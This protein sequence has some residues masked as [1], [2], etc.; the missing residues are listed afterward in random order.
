MLVIRTWPYHVLGCHTS[1][2]TWSHATRVPSCCLAMRL[3]ISHDT[4][5]PKITSFA[6]LARST[7][8]F[9]MMLGQ[10]QQQPRTLKF[11]KN[12]LPTSKIHNF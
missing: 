3:T 10:T 1:H 9:T 11:S 7:N 12:L 5:M 2:L 4:S 8:P 6:Y